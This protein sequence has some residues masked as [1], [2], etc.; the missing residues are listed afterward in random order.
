MSKKVATKRIR[1]KGYIREYMPNIIKAIER[2]LSC[3]G[4]PKPSRGEWK[5][6]VDGDIHYV[7]TEGTTAESQWERKHMQKKQTSKPKNSKKNKHILSSGK[8]SWMV[9][10]YVEHIFS[11]LLS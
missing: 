11:P 8:K 10:D 9:R 7:T 3:R 4:Y 1:I 5:K 2:T 6:N